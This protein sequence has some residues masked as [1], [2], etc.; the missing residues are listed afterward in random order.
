[1]TPN[2]TLIDLDSFL[3]LLQ[4]SEIAL[5]TTSVVCET[6]PGG[7]C[8]VTWPTKTLTTMALFRQESATVS[9]YR[10]WVTNQGYSAILYDGSLIQVSF[11]FHQNELIGHRLLYFP[12]PFDFDDK[13]VRS[14]SLVDVIEF[15]ESEEI[16]AVRLRAPIRFDYDAN[17]S[18]DEHPASHVTFQ[19]AHARVPN[20]SPISLGHFIDF[21][22]RNFYPTLWENHDFLRTWRQERL[23]STITQLQQR[24][25]HF[26]IQG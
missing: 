6:R 3:S 23:D 21:V 25:L 13:L 26:S 1:M 12:C 8:R 9:E 14:E 5:L 11:D 18:T 22:F 7:F 19:W 24:R 10:E 17:V 20:F 2:N 16:P 4:N 15:Y